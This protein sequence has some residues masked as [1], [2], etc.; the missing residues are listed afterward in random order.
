MKDYRD[1]GI[2]I[3]YG[4]RSGKVKCF[5]PQCHSSRRDKRDKSLS[6]DLDKGVW[7][8]HYCGWGGTINGKE[9]WEK[10]WHN[11]APIRRQ[12][13][14]YTKP[15]PK[16]TA[17]LSDKVIEY[18]KS[19]GISQMTLEA[20]KVTSGMEW[21]PNV[22]QDGKGGQ[23]NTI[24]FNFYLNGELVNVKYRDGYKHFRLIGGAQLIPYNIDAI[25]GKPEC[26]ITE[27][28]IDALSFHECGRTDVIS[29]PN[30]A[31]STEWLDDFLEEF[32]DNKEVIY[33]ASDTDTKGVQLRDELMRRFG[34]ERCRVLSYG[35]GCKDA[36]EHLIKYGKQSLLK[37]I[38][39]APETKLEGVFQ[40]SDFE[41]SLD[42][43]FENGMQKGVTIGHDCFDRLCSFETKRLCVVTG[44]PGSGKSE[45]IDEIAE[46]LNMRYG[47][48]FAYFS[49]E[50]APLAYHA[51]KL[52][53][54]FTGKKFDRQHLTHGEYRMVKA[55]IESN[56]F[57]ISPKDDYRLE[58]ILKKAKSLVRRKGIK[59][60]VIDPFN[61]LEDES[62]GQN[63]TKYIS[64]L[65][66]RL[67]NFAQQNDVLV[68][69]MVHPVKMKRNTDGQTEVPTLYDCSGSANFF[70]KTDFGIV[71]HRNRVEN[72]VE[73]HVQKVKFRHLGE[74]GMALFKYNLNNGRYV[75]YTNGIE[76]SWDNENH[77][78]REH[79]QKARDAEEAARFNFDDLPF[80]NGEE[81]DCPF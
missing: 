4:K 8:C 48:R 61:R 49:P 16:P 51:S 39:D 69:L 17:P 36:N 26:V 46:C 32:F 25:K 52:I 24:Q 11:N 76:P 18:F 41:D 57:F 71:V 66:D 72:T 30:G 13:P 6:I 74:C 34:P 78:I 60:L 22:G 50:N 77:L 79:E 80:A 62:D 47:W 14:E 28:E 42:A 1:F 29:V 7:N 20:L 15:K 2:E 70:N 63:E 19:R 64:R 58:T 10:P 5:C 68:I 53:E 45:F 73:V 9:E 33:I 81:E 75:P 56:F 37:C 59:T 38:A 44:I 40:V 43:L 27:G 35:E 31:N 54:K 65:L 23:I 21:M 3:P 67:T 12:K 55:H